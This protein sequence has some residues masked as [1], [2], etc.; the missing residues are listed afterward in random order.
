MTGRIVITRHFGAGATVVGIVYTVI[1]LT[2]VAVLVIGDIGVH[3]CLIMAQ[4]HRCGFVVV[5]GIIVPIVRRTPG[6]IA[7]NAPA[8]KHRRSAHEYR[9]N[10][11]GRAIHIRRADNLYIRG[12]VTHLHGQC[13]HILE[14]VLCQNR[15]NDYYVVVAVNSLYYAQVIDIPVM[16]EVQRRKHIGGGVEQHLELFER[17]GFGE[18]GTYCAEIEEETDIFAQRSHF[19]NSCGRARRRSLDYGRGLGRLNIRTA[20]DNAGRGLC[21]YHSRSRSFGGGDNAGDATAHQQCCGAKKK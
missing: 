4:I 20:V 13:S 17:V 5:M 2:M 11:V 12:A 7:V 6:I 21:V 10:I 18:S 3:V 14:N 1:V 16:V 15:L 9:A 19:H 8:C